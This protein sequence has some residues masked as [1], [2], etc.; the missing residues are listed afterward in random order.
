MGEIDLRGW[1]GVGIYQ[2]SHNMSLAI[3]SH[4]MVNAAVFGVFIVVS[5]F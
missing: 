4:A 3:Q 5:G 2:V 1:V